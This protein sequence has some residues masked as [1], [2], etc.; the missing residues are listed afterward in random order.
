MKSCADK[1][2]S[3][4]STRSSSQMVILAYP[5]S[6][7][8]QE[9]DHILMLDDTVL[10]LDDSGSNCS[11]TTVLAGVFT[12]RA[13]QDN[14]SPPAATFRHVAAVSARD[15]CKNHIKNRQQTLPNRADINGTRGTRRT[16]VSHSRD[17]LRRIMLMFAQPAHATTRACNESK[18][19]SHYPQQ[20]NQ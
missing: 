7:Q 5:T 18:Q 9:N 2:N 3:L 6:D 8:R 14:C 13:Q 17:S 20:E 19:A 4:L 12:S 1:C 11:P 10:F 16:Y 15:D